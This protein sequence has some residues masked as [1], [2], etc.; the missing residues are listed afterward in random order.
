MSARSLADQRPIRSRGLRLLIL[1]V[2]IFAVVA[3]PSSATF[4]GVNGLISFN[5]YVERTKSF[6]IFTATRNGGDVRK[7]TFNPNHNSVLPDWS[8]DGQRIAFQSDR[9]DVDGRK[10]AVQTYLMNADGSGLTQLTRGPGFQGAPGWSP[11]AANLAIDAD[12]GG[13]PGLQGIWVIPAS[14][15]D[16]V[17]VSEARRLTT[18]PARAKF[19]SE[20]QFSPDGRSIVFTRFR[21]LSVSAIHRVSIDGTGLDR[22][23]PWRLNASDPDWSPNGLKIT[24]D[25]GDA[26]KAGSKGDIYVMRADGNGRKV[27]T[28]HPR[29]RKGEPFDLANNPVWSPSGTKIMYSH[30]LP[31]KTVLEVMKPNGSGKHLVVGG[32]FGRKHFPNKVDWGTHP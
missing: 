13:G 6:E 7:L 27:L 18:I 15:P 9:V 10:N 30:F 14:D 31:E 8:P 17:V 22:L 28:D 20:P 2:V 4:P 5:A 21:S 29:L 23:T 24:F 1:A 25:S 19:D 32:R 3:A 12:W 26:G 11:D 16:G